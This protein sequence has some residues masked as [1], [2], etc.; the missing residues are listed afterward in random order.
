MTRV[1]F[2]N[3]ERALEL[4]DMIRNDA[5]SRRTIGVILVACLLLLGLVLATSNGLSNSAPSGAPTSPPAATPPLKGAVSAQVHHVSGHIWVF[6][7]TVRN[8]GTSPIG[9]FQLNG[10]AAN[11]YHVRERPSWPV[12]GN[13]ICGGKYPGVLVYWSTG[14]GSGPIAPGKAGHFSFKVNTTGS[15]P[16]RYSLSFGASAPLFGTVAGPVPSKL[17]TNGTCR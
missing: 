13:G 6:R 2:T 16:L 4:R 8:T 17:P 11:L 3:R 9:G 15:V 10:Q 14:G 1:S 7:Y 12:F 5:T